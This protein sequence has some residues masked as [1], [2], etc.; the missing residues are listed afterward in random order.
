MSFLLDTDICSA[1]L[2]GNHQVGSR[3]EQYGGGLHIS[4]I[5]AAELFTWGLREKSPPSRMRGLPGLSK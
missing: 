3:V 5:T 4:A 1:Y 2:K